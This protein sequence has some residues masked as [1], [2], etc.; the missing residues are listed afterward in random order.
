MAKDLCCLK[1]AQLIAIGQTACYYG[2]KY[3]VCTSR[4]CLAYDNR[5]RLP[6]N[7]KTCTFMGLNDVLG[8]TS[9]RQQIQNANWLAPC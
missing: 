2:T 9:F 3:S 1:Q 8:Q 6:A 4:A 7:R 5:Q